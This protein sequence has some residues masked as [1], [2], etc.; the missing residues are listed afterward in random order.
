MVKRSGP[1]R[2]SSKNRK[3]LKKTVGKKRY[4]A[5]LARTAKKKTTSVKKWRKAPNEMDLVLKGKVV[6]GGRKKRKTKRG[7]NGRFVKS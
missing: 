4:A 6:D 7:K 5:D 1:S 2:S 3:W